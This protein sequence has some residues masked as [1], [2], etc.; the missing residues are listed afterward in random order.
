MRELQQILTPVQ[1][2]KFIFWVQNNPA[3]MGMLH[4]LWV[5]TAAAVAQPVSGGGGG[6]G[7]AERAV[8]GSGAASASS[9]I[10]S[11][12]ANIS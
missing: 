3:C 4:K 11:A 10:S 1:S 6:A 2:A 9:F 12:A 5:S 7:T 8:D